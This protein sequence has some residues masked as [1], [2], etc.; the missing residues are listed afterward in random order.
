MPIED[1]CPKQVARICHSKMVYFSLLVELSFLNELS[2]KVEDGLKL[3]IIQCRL[4][5]LYNLS[6]FITDWQRKLGQ[7]KICSKK[8]YF[9]FH[10]NPQIWRKREIRKVFYCLE[11]T[12]VPSRLLEYVIQKCLKTFFFLYFS[13]L[14]GLSFLNELSQKI[15]IKQLLVGLSFL[16]ELSQKVE[17]GLKLKIIQCRLEILYNLSIFVTDWQRKLG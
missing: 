6:I 2:Q 17:D 15:G 1:F 10:H 11:R 5:I 13:L 3:K 16:N 12:S 7:Y 8:S 14:V 4:E 9:F